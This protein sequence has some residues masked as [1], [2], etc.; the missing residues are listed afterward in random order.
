M[1]TINILQH[2]GVEFE[3]SKEQDGRRFLTVNGSNPI[4]LNAD[5]IYSLYW[6]FNDIF[7]DLQKGKIKVLN[8]HLPSNNG[9]PIVLNKQA[10]ID[11]INEEEKKLKQ[12]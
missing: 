6:F 4:E 1:K 2:E 10:P 3:Y 12:K 8:E 11:I 9:Y 5:R 7:D